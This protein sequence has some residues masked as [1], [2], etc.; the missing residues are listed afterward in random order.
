MI[1]KAHVT[2]AK[3]HHP[4]KWESKS[5]KRKGQETT[6]FPGAGYEAMSILKT[7][8][9]YLVFDADKAAAATPSF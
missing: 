7:N 6:A 9:S 4:L 2:D 5:K 1:W 3:K 8:V